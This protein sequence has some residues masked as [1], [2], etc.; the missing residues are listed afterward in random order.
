M[1]RAVIMRVELLLAL[2]VASLLPR[3]A[4]RGGLGSSATGIPNKNVSLQETMG[5]TSRS[6]VPSPGMKLP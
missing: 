6:F 4:D 2:V 3:S 1:G 5:Q